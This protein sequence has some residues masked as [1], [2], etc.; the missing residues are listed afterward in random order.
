MCPNAHQIGSL[1]GAAANIIFEPMSLPNQAPPSPIDDKSPL[2][3]GTK[4]KD[5]EFKAKMA[6]LKGAPRRVR[7][8]GG[9]GTVLG[10]VLLLRFLAAAFAGHGAWGRAILSGI[11]QFLLFWFLS[12]SVHARVLWAWWVLLGLTVIHSWGPL[13]HTLRLARL[14]VEGGLAAH[15]RDIVYDL[16]GVIQ[17]FLSGFIVFLLLSKEVRD[18]IFT[19]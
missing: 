3:T 4:D 17:F 2:L 9:Y 6:E 13:G 14:T 15:G 11:A 18:Y 10:V 12:F 16:T 8:V 5:A 1:P 7:Q 19:K